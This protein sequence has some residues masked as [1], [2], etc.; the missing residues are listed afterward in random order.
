MPAIIESIRA[1]RI[2][3]EQ[4]DVRLLMFVMNRLEEADGW[5]KHDIN[6]IARLLEE[7][8]TRYDQKLSTTNNVLLVLGTR[9][10][11]ATCATH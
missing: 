11:R 5:S 4:R 8:M 6:E 9:L 2:I 1:F 3:S 10:A 7:N